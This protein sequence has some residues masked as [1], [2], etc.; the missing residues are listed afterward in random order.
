VEVSCGAMSRYHGFMVEIVEVS[1]PAEM[2][3]VR[4]LF[5]EY[6]KAVGVD[7]WFGHAFEQ[8]LRELP[9]PYL[10][11]AGRLVVAREGGQ[12]AGC[13]GLRPLQPGVVELRR[14]WVRGPYRKK[15]VGKL[16]TEALVAWARAAGCR[17]VRLETLSVMPQADALFRG[18]GF[19]P[20]P[21]DR[22]SPFPGSRLLE[23]KL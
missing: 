3:T 13:G 5:D 14:L 11:P 23:L 19:A 7:L 15:G 4:V 2:A 8:E 16:I 22:T 10:G 20:I 18:L 12:V 21:D 1:S 9:A 6:K 17:S